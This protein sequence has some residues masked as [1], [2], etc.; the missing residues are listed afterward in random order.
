MKLKV[1]T[2]IL[3]GIDKTG[4]DTIQ[5]YIYRFHKGKYAVYNRGNI[6]NAAY[7]KIYNRNECFESD[8]PLNFLYVLLTVE[9]HDLKIR[10][11]ITSEPKQD[12]ERHSIIFKEV[13]YE[14]TEGHHR[15]EFN[16]TQVTPYNIAKQIIEYLESVNK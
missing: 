12:F 7:D 15:L 10:C 8:L 9:P 1:D 11:E 6:S 16:T 4:K 3:E 13:F 5:Q 14:K 2:V